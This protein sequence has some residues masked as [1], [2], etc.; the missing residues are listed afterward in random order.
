[1]LIEAL[2]IEVDSI[3]AHTNH[4]HG[5]PTVFIVGCCLA[6]QC[7][8]ALSSSFVSFYRLM[9]IGNVLMLPKSPFLL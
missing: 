5:P 6:S 3:N 8:R 4:R 9:F 7:C 1:M 2:T